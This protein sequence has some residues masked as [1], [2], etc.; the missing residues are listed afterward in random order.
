[1]VAFYHPLEYRGYSQNWSITQSDDGVMFFANGDGVLEYDGVEWKMHVIGERITP[2]S[3]L[4]D[5]GIVWVGGK[6][7]FG[8]LKLADNGKH[9]FISLKEFIP[10]YAKNI[11]F[12][13][14]ILKKDRFI[15]FS[16]FEMILIWDGY[17]MHLHKTSSSTFVFQAGE[18]IL[19]FGNSEG[20]FAFDGTSRKHIL[21]GDFFRDKY[22]RQVLSYDSVRSLVITRKDGL[23][24]ITIRARATGDLEIE[25][26]EEFPSDCYKMASQDVIYHAIRLSDGNYAISTMLGGTYIMDKHG[27]CVA[28]L[29][30]K[31]GI[32]NE[33]HTNLYQDKEHNLWIALDNGIAKVMLASNFSFFNDRWNLLG[34]VLDIKQFGKYIVAGTWQGV[35]VYP[36]TSRDALHYP[37]FIEIAD[38]K[39]Q[40]WQLEMVKNQQDSFVIAA[41]SNGL[42]KIDTSLSVILLDRDFYY[43]IV[44]HPYFTDI[45]FAGTRNGIIIFQLQNRSF[46]RLKNFEFGRDISRTLDLVIDVDG[47]VWAAVEMYGIVS[48]R[49][50]KTPQNEYEFILSQ[51]ND[52]IPFAQTYNI[53]N[54][55]SNIIITSAKN[56]FIVHKQDGQNVRLQPYRMLEQYIIH[57]LNARITKLSY[58]EQHKCVYFQL[59]K[60][61]I[62]QYYTG[63]AYMHDGRIDI[64][65]S[66][67]KLFPQYEVHTFYTNKSGLTWVGCDDGIFVFNRYV[68]RGRKDKFKAIIRKIEIS[69]STNALLISKSSSTPVKL[70]AKQ[71]NLR[72][73]FSANSYIEEH[74]LYFRYKLD[75]FDEQWSPWT[76]N[77]VKEY[78]NLPH[79]NYVFYVQ[80]KDVF[81]QLSEVSS[82]QFRISRPWYLQYHFF[83][84]YGIFIGLSAYGI[85]RWSHRRL[86]RAKQRLETIIDQ[87]THEI[88]EQKQEL[89]REKEKSDLLLLNILPVKI[90]EELKNTGYSRAQYYRSATVLFTDFAGFTRLAEKE[91]PQ[92]LVNKLERIFLIFD[93]IVIRNKL[94]KIKTIGDSHMS[95]GG[96][97]VPNNTHVFDAV[98]AAIEMI[99]SMEKLRKRYAWAEE[100][101]LRIGIH[102]GSLIAGIIGKRKFAYDVWGDTVNMSSRLQEASEKDR[103]NISQEVYNIIEPYFECEARGTL[104]V[105]H[106]GAVE[107]YF[108]NRLK[109]EYSKNPE[110]TKPNLKFR[111][112]Y[113][114]LFKIQEYETN[115]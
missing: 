97:P 85:N 77:R 11:G 71:N 33:T 21:N 81:D 22:V 34:S 50:Q 64:D 113:W 35:Y 30:R 42:Y 96:I 51:Y 76:K 66:S 60:D 102:T 10:E 73:T 78:T 24:L 68:Q 95:V 55:N 114:R 88:A 109:P 41:T 65:L 84:L 67:F 56:I 62:A 2:S 28:K 70:H 40:T 29:D 61:N 94:E 99:E 104:P 72:F 25:N 80:A 13:L 18:Y 4:Y 101:N 63:I 115:I 107:M 57:Y 52:Q 108:V 45:F 32:P 23:F 103:I 91:E 36:L 9:E 59:K 47:M 15:Y 105:K 106:K 12:V 27:F 39:T 6:N 86:I 110:G 93:D 20:L 37:A 75:G 90:A 83:A 49:V 26:I 43:S 53:Y 31:V 38:I 79:G 44:R 112:M 87:R 100:W 89:E 69:P 82:F 16:A 74:N 5:Q 111:E 3:L 19:G 7:E 98:L 1:M 58:D 46:K 54:I 14:R 17:R 48:I 8:Y 92:E